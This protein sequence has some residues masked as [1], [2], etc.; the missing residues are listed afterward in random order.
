MR[1]LAS[2]IAF[3]LLLVILYYFALSRTP[4]ML[5]NHLTKKIGVAIS[6]DAIKPKGLSEINVDTLE[7]ANAQGYTLP[8]AFSARTIELHAPITAYFQDQVVVDQINVDDIYLGIEFDTTSS[9]TGNWTQ[10]LHH[11][12][13][14]AHLDANDGKRVLI[15]KMIFTNINSDLIFH[16]QGGKITKLPTIPRIELTNIST[17]GGLPIDQLTSS[18]LGQM[19]KQAFMQYHLNNMIQG[20]IESPGKALELFIKPFQGIFNMAPIQERDL[21]ETA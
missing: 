20:L 7:I 16:S 3:V 10:L 19:L 4:D 11:Y 1:P 21:K 2:L 8:K 17:E 15:K 13:T 14:E 12:Q 9:I 6:I 5:A 18:I